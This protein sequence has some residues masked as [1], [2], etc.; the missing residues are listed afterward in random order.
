MPEYLWVM[1]YV[2]KIQRISD[3]CRDLV[4]I[5]DKAALMA[6]MVYIGHRRGS[7]NKRDSVRI[8]DARWRGTRIM[9]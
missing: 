8:S 2:T 6:P 9:G 1:V 3:K 7:Q 4:E 5:D